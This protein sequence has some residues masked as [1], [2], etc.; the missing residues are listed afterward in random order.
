MNL[1]EVEAITMPDGSKMVVSNIPSNVT[2]AFTI[3]DD[4]TVIHTQEILDTETGQ[5]VAG[6][7]KSKVG[8][9]PGHVR[10]VTAGPLVPP[11]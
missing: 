11:D 6:L 9:F 2:T 5:I 8:G 10:G 3:G 4:G 1:G 7:N